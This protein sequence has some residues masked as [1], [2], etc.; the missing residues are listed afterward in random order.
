MQQ[1]RRGAATDLLF[2]HDPTSRSPGEPGPAPSLT[3]K[4][5][6]A[7][8]PAKHN[9]WRYGENLRSPFTAFRVGQARRLREEWLH[10]IA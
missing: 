3:P 8:S 7:S 2:P 5:S 9:S 10:E 1:T 4:R 6:M